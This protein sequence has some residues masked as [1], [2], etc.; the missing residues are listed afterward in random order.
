VHVDR[1]ARSKRSDRSALILPLRPGPAERQS[2][3]MS[4]M[5]RPPSSPPRKSP[6]GRWWHLLPGHRD[7]E[8]PKLLKRAAK[9]YPRTSC[10]AR[11]KTVCRRSRWV[12]LRHCVRASH[13]DRQR[14]R[15]LGDVPTRPAQRATSAALDLPSRRIEPPPARALP[16]AWRLDTVPR[17][18]FATLHRSRIQERQQRWRIMVGMSSLKAER[19]QGR[20][21]RHDGRP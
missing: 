20:L 12:I 8:S 5:A 1:R 4:G 21:R 10:V 6:P 18:I 3:R 7:E 15:H 11:E 9:A 14:H 2:H 16:A 19:R 17:P 13:P